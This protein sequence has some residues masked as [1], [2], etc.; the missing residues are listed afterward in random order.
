MVLYS[1]DSNVP[2]YLQMS[3]LID[4]LNSWIDNNLIHLSATEL[5]LL[6]TEIVAQ[7]LKEHFELQKDVPWGFCSLPVCDKCYNEYIKKFPLK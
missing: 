5:I 3:Q 2:H 6:R 7:I 4:I 1:D